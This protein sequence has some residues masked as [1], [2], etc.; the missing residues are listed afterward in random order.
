MAV[1]ALARQ[2]QQA[3]P[4]VAEVARSR[5]R[6]LLEPLPKA[7]APSARL[8][9]MAPPQA[10]RLRR[11]PESPAPKAPERALLRR[12]A[13]QAALLPEPL[14]QQVA[15]ASYPTQAQTAERRALHRS[16]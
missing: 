6:A 10:R 2:R 14:R 8:P 9:S 5:Q 3:L 16:R 13:P 4:A 1:R 15:P 7:A 12:Q 11:S